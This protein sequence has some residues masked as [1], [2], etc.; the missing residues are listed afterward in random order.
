V[1]EERTRKL[2]GRERE[3]QR[4]RTHVCWCEW[5]NATGFCGEISR[6]PLTTS[7]GGGGDVDGIVTKPTDRQ[8]TETLSRTLG[9]GH[10][11]CPNSF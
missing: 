10:E 7:G 1:C 2:W 9:L 5:L 4:V 3:V 11:K 6:M 8:T